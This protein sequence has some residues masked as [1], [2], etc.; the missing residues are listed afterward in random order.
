MLRPVLAAI[1]T[2]SEP[3]ELLVVSSGGPFGSLFTREFAGRNLVV[4]PPMLTSELYR[5]VFRDMPKFGL[6]LCDLAADDFAQFRDL[7]EKIRPLMK[8]HSRVVV[9]HDNLMG[10]ALDE[11]TFEFTRGLF[12]LVGRSRI[13]FGGSYVGALAM[14]WFAKKLA[15]HNLARP[16]SSVA[17]AASLP[18]WAP[19]AR[20]AAGIEKRRNARRLPAHCTSMV[21]EID[22]P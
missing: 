17:L 22:L 15:R 3:A 14:R 7:L 18:V 13:S 4:T 11:R 5:Q 10:R 1:G 9:F 12:P 2:V 16:A 8:D 21:I 19:L 20:L 6:C